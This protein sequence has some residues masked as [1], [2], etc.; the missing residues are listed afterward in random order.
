LDRRV[1][2]TGA[3]GFTGQRVYH[4]LNKK[5]DVT[6]FVR[7]TS[8]TS[9][10]GDGVKLAYGDLSDIDSLKA[11][12]EGVDELVYVASME[13]GHG[14]Q[15]VK[16]AEESG[17]VRSI[18]VSTTGI[19]TALNPDL[20]EERS[21]AEEAVKK[22]GLS[23]TLIRPTMIYGHV[24]DRNM[25]RLISW[26]KKYP[27]FLMPGGGKALQQPVH[28]D[29]LAEGIVRAWSKKISRKKIY[30]MSG[31]EPEQ[32]LSVVQTIGK[33]LHRK[34]WMIP[35]PISPFVFML[36]LYERLAYTP[37]IRADQIQRFSENK[38]FGHDL[39]R[40][41]LGFKPRSFAE[42]IDTLIEELAS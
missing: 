3:T 28:V 12:M 16:A 35:L 1:L 18:F 41:D 6:C 40:E 36:R 2:L 21:L 33:K 9:V 20:K 39:A 22:S 25:E 34:I 38:A 27:V 26:L 7:K 37:R 42:G 10:L 4:L 23:W 17:I 29:D 31:K 5:A 15:A 11:A 30:T 32:L 8:D 13:N 24:G 14:E 19:L